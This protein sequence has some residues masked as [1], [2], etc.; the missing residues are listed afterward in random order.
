MAPRVRAEVTEHQF[1]A[2]LKACRCVRRAVAA[3]DN[4]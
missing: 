1:F 4:L 3:L 2:C